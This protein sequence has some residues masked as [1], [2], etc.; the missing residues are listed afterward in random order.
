M[1]MHECRFLPLVPAITFLLSFIAS[2]QAYAP[3]PQLDNNFRTPKALFALNPSI[4]IG[5][6]D[7]VTPQPWT[8][9]G[10]SCYA[11]VSRPSNTRFS[12]FGEPKKPEVV[13]IHGFGCSTYYWRETCKAL[14]EAGYTVH[15]LDLLGQGKSAKP[16]RADGVEYSI[17]LWARLVEEYSRQFIPTG[18]NVVLMGNSLGS[19]VA[20]S[21]ATGDHAS[22]DGRVPTLP[23]RIQGIGM[24]NCGVGMNSR[25]LLKDP[26]LTVVQKVVFTVLFDALDTLIFDNVPLLT[27]LLNKVVTRELLRNALLGLYK[28]SSDPSRRVDDALVDSFYLP[29]KDAGSVEALNQIYTNDAGKTPMQLQQD[30]ADLLNTTPIHL[31]WGRDD[32][33]TPLGGPVG[34]FYLELVKDPSIPVSFNAVDAG[35]VP[36]DEVPECNSFMIRW[37][38][39]VVM[40]YRP[41]QGNMN[42]SPFQWFF[43][44]ASNS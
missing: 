32:Q 1:P 17:N 23:T 36:F 14:T 40:A 9:Q 33:V 35:H 5:A 44:K 20:L 3:H 25:N 22:V 42:S 11:E 10:H 34:Q 24:F 27:Y 8:F 6:S 4:S 37:L 30:Y 2:S 18:T 26:N 28:C 39:D 12:L 21:A 29:A 38:D 15:A 13:L 7:P 41:P 19:V 31:V 43:A 16:G